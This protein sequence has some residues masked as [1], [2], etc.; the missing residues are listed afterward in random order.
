MSTEKE[1][2]KLSI[3]RKRWRNE[4]S[5]KNLDYRSYRPRKKS[6]SKKNVEYIRFPSSFSI[7]STD[8]DSSYRD[9]MNI[10]HAISR[11]SRSQSKKVHLDFSQTKSIK[12]ASVLVLYATIELS[13][14]QGVNFKIVS[15]PMEYKATRVIK[16][17]GL[18]L[19]CRESVSIPNFDGDYI[20]VISGSGGDYRDDIVDFIQ[21]KI[22]KNKMSALTESIY[23]GAIHEAINNVAYHA[24]PHGD[25]EKSWWVKCDLA[26]DQLFLAIY[27]KG[28]GIPET[29]M[30]RA[31]YGN[32]LKQTYPQI[33]KKIEEEL[34][35]EGVTLNDMIS[36]KLGRVTDA[37]KI[38]ISMVGDVTGTASSKHGQ[39]SKSIKALV[40]DND[41]GTLWIYSND[42]LYK[43]NSGSIETIELPKS[44][45]GTLIQWNIK[46]NLDEHHKD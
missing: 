12:V 28:V 45:P 7:Y 21:Q 24:Y 3:A 41:K 17:S 40:E 14:K 9:T 39:G 2:I 10:I 35:K 22:Y 18:V 6:P 46:V 8:K 20:P 16:R 29:V 27:D 32:I 4:L 30:K 25:D 15:F 36:Y 5:R 37:M 23:G 19:L 38:A 43:L 13:I 1:E 34:K 33:Q 44:M 42:G 31:W 26:G 11:L